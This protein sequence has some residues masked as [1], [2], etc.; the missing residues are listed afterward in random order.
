[1]SIKIA[2]QG[3]TF[4]QKKL[5]TLNF[6]AMERKLVISVINGILR[7]H[8]DSEEN[9]LRGIA[10]WLCRQMNISLR[11]GK[12]N[13]TT[14]LE[15]LFID[16][17]DAARKIALYLS[18]EQLHL[19][20]ENIALTAEILL[21]H[22]YH[23]GFKSENLSFPVTE[24]AS[25]FL[26]NFLHPHEGSAI[27][28]PFAGDYYAPA[29]YPQYRFVSPTIDGQVS[30][31]AIL[32]QA[33]RGLSNSTY[34]TFNPFLNSEGGESLYDSIYIPAMP[35]GVK[36]IGLGRKVEETYI[37]NA[38]RLLRDGG[39]MVVVL[40]ALALT[41]DSFFELRKTFLDKR[42]LRRVI[43]LSPKA[44]SEDTSVNA[45]VFVLENSQNENP[46]FYFHDVSKRPL[47]T[48]EDALK[49][50]DRISINEPSVSAAIEYDTPLSTH[51]V[52]I[53]PPSAAVQR[54][55]RPGFKYVRL[56]DL[57]S[58]Y[59]KSVELDG[60]KMVARLSGKD[61]H[62][63][64]PDYMIDI[65]DVEITAARGRFT[66]IEE[67]VLCFHGITQNYVWCVGEKD[68][69]VYCNSDIYTFKISSE[70]ISPEYLCFVLSQE[71]IKADIKNR[72]TGY[73]IPRI[74]R[75]SLLDVAIPVP[76]KDRQ[77][78]ITQALQQFVSDQKTMLVEQQKRSHEAD[79]EDIR[80][81]IK[82]KIHLLGPYNT[83]VQTGINRIIKML[84]R[85]DKLEA[86]TVVYKD[87]SIE[88]L[89]FLKSLLVKSEDAGYIMASIGES[90]FEEA[91]QPL[92]AS[93]F[94]QEYV[95]RLQSDEE[96]EGI[97]FEITPI[98]QPH[99]M[100]ITERSLRLVLDTIVRNAVLHGFSD[101]FSG[102]RKIRFSLDAHTKSNFAVISI[103]NNGL[104]PAEG[105][106]QSLYEGKFG[107]CGPTAHSGRGGFFVSKAM[108]FY[109][110]YLFVN[111]GD[112][113]WPFD[114]WLH[115]PIS[116]E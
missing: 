16:G 53:L 108:A 71:D 93:T 41:A 81:D 62:L 58:P 45:V 29:R 116:H 15:D 20:E 36:I 69:P 86:G 23:Y 30:D 85:G 92:D 83:N 74:T 40:P 25:R 3:L 8:F 56:N 102:P 46:Y 115:I 84:Q 70:L 112:K 110:G 18:D 78:L 64:L 67:P 43:L 50:L 82:D 4:A 21:L 87:S 24:A 5:F 11:D 104:P 100:M 114:V 89:G 12:E 26:F 9:T 14:S 61:M 33:A 28:N 109:K 44:L 103:A 80:E 88:L 51:N 52:Q 96:Y 48:E 1:M 59:R 66:C 60:T 68:Y 13:S 73:G 10:L 91:D 105:F 17:E 106:T 79:I 31:F 35:F 22:S 95:A 47:L 39:R 57:L 6:C 65:Q 42:I 111:T 72:V 27:Y 101:A 55:E 77:D 54:I 38:L 49:L 7:N 107:K 90:I 98:K 99:Y 19:L 97:S 63:T 2:H 75:Q 37:L 94:I 113:K 34:F 76:D 32:Y